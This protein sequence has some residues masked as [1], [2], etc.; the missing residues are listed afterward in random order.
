MAYKT[1]RQKY[2]KQLASAP[3]C[4]GKT[5]YWG[6]NDDP[7]PNPSALSENAED[8]KDEWVQ[9]KFVPYEV[10][11]D[12]Y[13]CLRYTKLRGTAEWSL[14]HKKQCFLVVDLEDITASE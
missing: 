7:T 5:Y 2:N 4:I 6:Y 11:G 13:V 3:T 1:M 12:F 10:V 9:V 8:F 14:S